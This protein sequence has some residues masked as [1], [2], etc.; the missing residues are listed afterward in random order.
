MALACTGNQQ[1]LLYLSLNQDNT[2]LALA[3][4]EGL[5]IY[6]IDT[7]Q[8]VYRNSVGA[9]GLAEMLFCTS[10]VAY[11][12]AGEQPALT[13]RKLTVMNTSNEEAIQNISF[14]SSVLAVRM[15]RQRLVVILER[16]ANV[17]SLDSL[18]HLRSLE[19]APNPRGLAALT[20][21]AGPGD[22]CLL[23]LPAG[24]GAGA[25][26]VY[27]V[28][29]ADGGNALSEIPAHKA[30]LAA[31]A[32][33]S[34][35]A[36]LA[37]ASSTGTVVRVHAVQPGASRVFSFR[38]GAGRAAVSCLA[39]SPAGVEPRLLAAASDHG[40]VHIF[41]LE[42]AERHPALAAASAA[43]GLLSAVMRLPVADMVDPVRDI[44][45]VRLPCQG[46][47]CICALTRP[48]GGGGGGGAG[49]G[50]AA[51]AGSLSELQSPG[52][53][54]SLLVATSEGI[55]YEYALEGL[56]GPQGPRC[57]LGGEWALLGS[58][59]LG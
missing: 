51:S 14:A 28:A 11:V 53:A 20:P 16:R 54:L 37:T 43:A 25:L 44:A 23:A 10:L 50:A 6:S 56:A 31:M 8:V 46:V 34:D 57:A 22:P 1:G 40:T 48:G 9:L 42:A 30:P 47:P 49:G 3:T 38:R 27:D 13:P 52:D 2:C 19:T 55:L 45:T 26:Q 15:N 12:G 35:G 29:A 21:A 36:L 18:S 39:F 58:A 5:R 59:G 24:G 33:S 7:H 32:W 4:R 17:Y 41:R